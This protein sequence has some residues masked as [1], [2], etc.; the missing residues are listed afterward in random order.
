MNDSETTSVCFWDIVLYVKGE[1]PNNKIIL[2]ERNLVFN[3]EAWSLME[4]L[5]EQFQQG[6]LDAFLNDNQQMLMDR[7]TKKEVQENDSPV[8]ETPTRTMPLRNIYWGIAASVVIGLLGAFIWVQSIQPPSAQKR[9]TENFE[10]YPLF[11]DK[12]RSTPTDA[13]YSETLKAYRNENFEQVN[14]YFTAHPPQSEDQWLMWLSTS[15]AL[16]QENTVQTILESEARLSFSANTQAYFSWYQA[17]WCLK[18]GNTTEA[19]ALLK[20]VEN[21]PDFEGKS[22]KLIEEF[23]S[24]N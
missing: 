12:V 6:T 15:M 13:E 22:I 3:Q 20:E 8:S 16:G 9:Y 18:K 2:I 24:A 5:E 1:L 10:P 23:S 17:L 21:H 19:I 14:A 4:L 7:L 11:S